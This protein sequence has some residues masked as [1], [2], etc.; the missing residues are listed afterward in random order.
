[1]PTDKLRWGLLSTA[2]INDAI[3]NAVEASSRSEIVAVAS[4]DL[5]RAR[6]YATAKNIPTAYASYEQLLEDR[7]VDAVYVSLPNTLH[8]K[9]TVQAANHGKHVLCE[10]PIVASL[11]QLDAIESAAAAPRSTIFNSHTHLHHPHTLRPKKLIT[12]C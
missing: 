3:L 1:M 6:S 10:K 4:R 12:S 2:A 5:A 11:A 9:W 8:A 7:S